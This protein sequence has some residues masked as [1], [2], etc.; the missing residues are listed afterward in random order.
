V[1]F[2]LVIAYAAFVFFSAAVL[3]NTLW[4]ASELLRLST[5]NQD[6]RSALLADPQKWLASVKGTLST[7]FPVEEVRLYLQRSDSQWEYLS[8]T[9][10][11]LVGAEDTKTLTA[12]RR[13]GP[14]LTLVHGL[15]VFGGTLWI[16]AYIRLPDTPWVLEITVDV[17]GPERFLTRYG[18]EVLFYTLL[19]CILSLLLGRFLALHFIRPLRALS[20]TAERYA[21]GDEVS[22]IRDRRDE[23]GILSRTLNQMALALEEQKREVHNRLAAMESMNKIDKAVLLARGRSELLKTVI[24]EVH[25]SCHS[26]AAA[27]F[28]RDSAQGGWIVE[29]LTGSLGAEGAFISDALIDDETTVNLSRFYEGSIG[30]AGR[31]FRG[32]AQDVLELKS[33]RLSSIPLSSEGRYFGAL[34]IAW[35]EDR[36]LENQQKQSVMMLADQVAVALQSILTREEKEENFIGILRALTRAIDAKSQWTLG[37]SERVADTAIRLGQRLLMEDEELRLLRIAAIL[38]DVGKIGINETIL[39]K[40][41]KL[42]SLEFETMRKHPQVGAEILQ[43][44]RSFESIVP[45]V[46]HHHERW[47]GQGYPEGLAGEAIPLWARIIAVADVWD[48]ITDDRPYRLAFAEAEALA[49]ME[50]QAGRMFDPRLVR[51][52]RELGIH[53]RPA[54]ILGATLS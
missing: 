10:R 42:D 1:V 17:E 26:H 38:H 18:N 37:H 13:A 5:G 25:G 51:I 11:G 41:G 49:F 43:G 14:R 39:D 23:I 9:D 15:P 54:S 53:S 32:I 40:P 8:S 6:E 33:G 21:A 31:S 29:A 52:F 34:L 22:F 16:P 28:R 35:S 47:D 44:I 20:A 7:L 46:R 30:F 48:A 4:G 27:L 12:L 36:P 2:G 19:L 45:A 50:Q 3:R 24:D